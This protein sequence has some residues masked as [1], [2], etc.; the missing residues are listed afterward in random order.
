VLK[1]KNLKGFN[2]FSTDAIPSGLINAAFLIVKQYKI[3]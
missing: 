1:E 2:V 3:N